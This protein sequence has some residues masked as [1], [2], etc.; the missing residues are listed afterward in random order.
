MIAIFLF[1][2]KTHGINKS[3]TFSKDLKHCNIITFDG[4]GYVMTT[5]DQTGISSRIIRIG[6]LSKFLKRLPALMPDLSSIISTFIN[7]RAKR[8]WNPLSINSCNEVSRRISGI[9]LP[10]TFNVATLYYYLIYFNGKRE[11]DIDYI[12]R[13]T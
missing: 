6:N 2:D 8:K 12:W 7:C 13:R 3:L 5:L 11:Y 9:D 1:Y 10:I 4:R